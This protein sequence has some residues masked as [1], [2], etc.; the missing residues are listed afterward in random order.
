MPTEIPVFDSPTRCLWLSR[1]PKGLTLQL[2]DDIWLSDV[3][4][5]TEAAVRALSV[6]FQDLEASNESGHLRLRWAGDRLML[7][8]DS[9]SRVRVEEVDVVA[10]LA[11]IDAEG[12]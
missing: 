6:G 7:E 9:A 5:V 2:Q 1:T 8:Y 4:A 11:A 3:F 10:L 12:G